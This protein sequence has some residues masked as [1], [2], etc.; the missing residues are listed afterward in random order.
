MESWREQPRVTLKPF[1]ATRVRRSLFASILGVLCA[2]VGISAAPGAAFAATET[3]THPE[4]VV[5]RIE[6]V[7]ARLS[8]EDLGGTGDAEKS[9][10]IAQWYNWGN[11]PNFWNNFWNT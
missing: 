9:W 5:E 7:R 8:H 11:W 1:A 10:T 3:K 6:R 4:T 2:A